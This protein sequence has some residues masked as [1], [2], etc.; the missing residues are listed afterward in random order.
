M[1][2]WWFD[3]DA[4]RAT[5]CCWCGFD[6]AADG[7]LLMI[8]WCDS[9]LLLLLIKFDAD[10]DG[11]LLIRCWCDLML[12]M[13]V[14]WCGFYAAADSM[15]MRFDAAAEADLMLLLMRFNAADADAYSM[16][17]M[18]VCFDMWFNAAAAATAAVDL[19]LL[20]LL[21]LMW[22]YLIRWYAADL[23]LMRIWCCCG[24]FNFQTYIQRQRDRACW[25]G[26]IFV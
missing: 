2:C 17:L 19:L 15:M 26:L 13:M 8:C 3:A 14:C 23:I 1:V 11:M 4:I 5:Q 24:L 16:L 12:T 21:L 7:M 9:M 22:F 10:D 6:T 20:L 25:S 18:M